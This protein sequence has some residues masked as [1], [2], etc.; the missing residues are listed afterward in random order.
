V[1]FW[2]SCA[3][4]QEQNNLIRSFFKERMKCVYK[5][6]IQR[7]RERERDREFMQLESVDPTSG[8]PLH[9]S[10]TP[11]CLRSWDDQFLEIN[12]LNLSRKCV[13]I[14][15]KWLRTAGHWGDFSPFTYAPTWKNRNFVPYWIWTRRP[16]HLF[17]FIVSL[18]P[19]TNLEL[20]RN[21]IEKKVIS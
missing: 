5:E 1:N 19:L 12:C 3:C 13:Q 16:I 11:L 15:K 2:T 8:L 7:E 6:E 18:G 21:R 4:T 10:K 14:F 17:F 9:N 20:F